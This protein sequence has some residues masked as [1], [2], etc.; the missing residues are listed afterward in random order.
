MVGGKSMNW[1]LGIYIHKE[2][3]DR[4]HIVHQNNGNYYLRYLD[5]QKID[6][7]SEVEFLMNWK[8]ESGEEE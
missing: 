3:Q 4:A 7:I 6:T 8:H 1:R 2:S 5:K